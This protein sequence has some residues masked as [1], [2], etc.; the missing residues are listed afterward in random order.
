MSFYKYVGS[1]QITYPAYGGITVNPND[2]WDLGYAVPP[3]SSWNAD[4]GPATAYDPTVQFPGS[5]GN[6]TRAI[7]TPGWQWSEGGQLSYSGPTA[8]SATAGTSGAVPAQVAGYISIVIS[9][10][11]YKI[12][13]FA[14]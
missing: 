13:Y 3:D 11:T 12:P 1:S 9:G 7:D 8:A 4:P 10:S 2:V 5:T 6:S 14:N